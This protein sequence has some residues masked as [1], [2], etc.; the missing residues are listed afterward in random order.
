VTS[1]LISSTPETLDYHSHLVNI[2]RTKTRLEYHDQLFFAELYHDGWDLHTG[3][4]TETDFVRSQRIFQDQYFYSCRKIRWRA[5]LQKVT[6]KKTS[7]RCKCRGNLG[8]GRQ[9]QQIELI[10]PFV[11]LKNSL[12]PNHQQSHRLV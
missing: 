4:S 1:L 5:L 10:Y 2:S 8:D 7:H 9:Q 12:V 11:S 3:K 6:K